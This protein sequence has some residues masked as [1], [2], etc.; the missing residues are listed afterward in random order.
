M[1]DGYI[2]LAA[3]K[4]FLFWVSIV[5]LKRGAEVNQVPACVASPNC[6]MPPWSLFIYIYICV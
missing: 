5:S 3:C 4:I 1:K 6:P 2:G